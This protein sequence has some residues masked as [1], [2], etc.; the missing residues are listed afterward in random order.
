MKPYVVAIFASVLLLSFGEAGIQRGERTDWN[1]K[2]PW[3]GTRQDAT[4]EP[5]TPFKIFDNVYYV[6]LQTVCAYLVTT[7]NGLVL[8][9][10]TYAETAD[11]VLNSIRTLG[12]DPAN[13]KYIFI[14]HSHTDHLGGAAKIKQVSGAPVGMS[15][16]D[17]AVTNRPPIEKDL[18]LK[19]GETIKA[20]DTSFQFYVTPGHTPGATSIEFQVRD[21]GKTYRAL[22]PGGL[23]MQFG[24]AE[25]PIFLKSMERLKQLGPWDVML[26]NHPWLMPR[27]LDEIQKGLTNRGNA[28][29]P[30]VLGPAKINDWLDAVI[31]VTKQKLAAGQ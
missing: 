8:I 16:E 3:G 11:S 13:I 27:T 31:N 15:A 1:L 4:R 2:A 18:V 25:T 6:G 17:W 23:G 21:G 22:S 20:G 29:H 26:S 30:A 10:A 24:P 19:D 7:S 9:D 12:F 14:T 28:S 5:R